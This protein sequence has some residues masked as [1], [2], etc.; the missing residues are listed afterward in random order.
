MNDSLGKSRQPLVETNRTNHSASRTNIKSVKDGR[1]NSRSSLEMRRSSDLQRESRPKTAPSSLRVPHDEE[2]MDATRGTAEREV[3][4]NLQDE[5]DQAASFPNDEQNGAD[6]E[7]YPLRDWPSIGEDEARLQVRSG[8]A[9]DDSYRDNESE[10]EELREFES[11]ERKIAAGLQ[12]SG[13]M[14]ASASSDHEAAEKSDTMSEE[15]GED[16]Y[17]E[18]LD[19]EPLANPRNSKAHLVYGDDEV[20]SN[21]VEPNTG[22]ST[23]AKKGYCDDNNLHDEDFNDKDADHVGDKANT[24]SSLVT[25]FFVNDDKGKSVKTSLVNRNQGNKNQLV[26][27]NKQKKVSIASPSAEELKRTKQ[28]DEHEKKY[29]SEKSEGASVESKMLELE[30]EIME[31]R[32][33]NEMLQKVRSEV[34]RQRHALLSEKEG[35][36]K[37]LQ[38]AENRFEKYKEAEMKKLRKDRKDMERNVAL[39][40][41]QVQDIRAERD[42]VKKELQAVQ[43]ENSRKEKKLRSE[44]ERL[45]KKVDDLTAKNEEL[46]REL[47]FSEE[48]RLAIQD[49]EHLIHAKAKLTKAKEANTRDSVVPCMT[50]RSE[51]S[52]ASHIAQVAVDESNSKKNKQDDLR[53]KII[54]TQ[55][56]QSSPLMVSDDQMNG[57]KSRTD[58]LDET[59]IIDA[60]L[61]K[62]DGATTPHDESELVLEKQY[63]DGKIEKRYSD[64]RR[65]LIFSN[66]TS[67]LRLVL[68]QFKLILR[69]QGKKS[70]QTVEV[71]STFRTET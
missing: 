39:W 1:E 63:D 19:D 15:D 30:K 62:Q 59:L 44:I 37:N 23:S 49:R 17:E 60:G 22:L 27:P 7:F 33:Q 32:K 12:D 67:K 52:L 54:T 6:Q 3:A 64:G 40:Q 20:W 4:R 46:A 8:G 36:S 42:T 31:F 43:E 24:R 55:E 26:S 71:L 5:C 57:T 47:K 69:S 21:D 38:D 9:I 10:D 45:K 41:Q 65:V 11:I 18:D 2:D 28:V 25:K 58:L 16:I 34:E 66:G 50:P 13:T 51:D 56:K 29:S 14:R 61:R 53:A 70:F 48:A 68:T 35:L